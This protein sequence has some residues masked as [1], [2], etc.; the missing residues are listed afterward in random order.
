MR[1]NPEPDGAGLRGRERGP[2]PALLQNALVPCLKEITVSLAQ[3]SRRQVVAAVVEAGGLVALAACSSASS[4]GGGTASGGAAPGAAAAPG[5]VLSSLSAV[6]VGSSVAAKDA[7][8]GPVLVAQ[9]TSGKVVAFSA[10]CTHQGCTVAPAGTKFQCPCHG[11]MYDAA[12][13]AVLQGPAS[14]P[15][16]PVAVHVAGGNV[17]TG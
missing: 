17:V 11:S 3:P 5:T 10:I 13:G 12:T 14:R 1:F 6:P 9:P 16:T 15:L 8:G 4:S 7:S 2:V